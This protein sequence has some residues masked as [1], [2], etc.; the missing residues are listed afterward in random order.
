M[1]AWTAKLASCAP[2]M[3]LTAAIAAVMAAALLAAFV[4]TLREHL[5]QGDEFRQAQVA[6]AKRHAFAAVAD[7]GT[8]RV[9]QLRLR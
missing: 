4:G 9:E 1:K 8:A 3:W 7:A 2:P 5:R 6:Q